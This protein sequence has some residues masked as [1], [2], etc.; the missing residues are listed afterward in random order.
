MAARRTSRDEARADEAR[1]SERL[2]HLSSPVLM[3]WPTSA[4]AQCVQ[5]VSLDGMPQTWSQ[6]KKRSCLR[7]HPA[8]EDAVFNVVRPHQAL[9]IAVPQP[10]PG[11]T[12]PQR[13]PA[14]AGEIPD[15]IW[16]L[17]ALLASRVPP[18]KDYNQ[19]HGFEGQYPTCCATAFFHFPLPMWH[20][21]NTP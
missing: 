15:H 4:H 20:R 18:P 9:R 17:E 3:S 21:V 6:S 13:P 8:L 1:M 2:W 16:G 11:R 7:R 14:M 12:W 19:F 5:I 10:T